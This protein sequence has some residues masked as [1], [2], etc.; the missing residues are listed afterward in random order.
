MRAMSALL[1]RRPARRAGRSPR[2]TRRPAPRIEVQ[3]D[4]P[5][6]ASNA[7]TPV[8]CATSSPTGVSTCTKVSEPEISASSTLPGS[9]MSPVAARATSQRA[10]AHADRER[11]P[12]AP[13]GSAQRQHGAACAAARRRR[14]A[15]P[16]IRFIGGSLKAR[17][18]RIDCGAV[19]HLGGRPVLQQ[20]AGIHHR[21]VAAE[22]QR[23]GRARWWRRRRSSRRS[24]TAACSS[25]RSSSRSL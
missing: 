18:T 3:R 16:A 13:A 15:R 23:L 24:R 17:A 12:S 6:R 2:R 8:S 1:A 10:G 21:G 14:R 5:R 4:R 22:Q 25:S 7:C 11:A 20:L 19:E 9:A